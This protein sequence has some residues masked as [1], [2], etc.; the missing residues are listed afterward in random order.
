M[1]VSFSFTDVTTTFSVPLTHLSI[2]S[3]LPDLKLLMTAIWISKIYWIVGA[4]N[5]QQHKTC[6]I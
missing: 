2:T 3:S 6:L 5:R 4:G 1:P